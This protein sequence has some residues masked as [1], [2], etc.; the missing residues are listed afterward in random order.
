[1]NKIPDYDNDSDRAF[2]CWIHERLEHVHGENPLMSHM[3]R[4]RRF[5]EAAATTRTDVYTEGNN[6]LEELMERLEKDGAKEKHTQI[7]LTQFPYP[8]N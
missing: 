5:I 1:M 2:L 3:H 4:L 6:S 8:I 7:S